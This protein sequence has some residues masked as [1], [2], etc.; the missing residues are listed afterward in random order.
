M[1]V[2]HGQ[3]LDGLEPVDRNRFK[4]MDLRA[5]ADLT[6]F[7]KAPTRHVLLGM[8]QTTMKAA[9][10]DL[11]NAVHGSDLSGLMAIAVTAVAKRAV[12]STPPTI[13]RS[14]HLSGAGRPLVCG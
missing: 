14:R 12:G 8:Q 4:A 1:P 3:T 13:D 9:V 11:R 2:T 10:P 6:A 7:V 5:I